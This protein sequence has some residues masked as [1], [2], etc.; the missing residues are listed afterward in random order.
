MLNLFPAS[1]YLFKVNNK[2]TR[3]QCKT[4]PKLTKKIPERN[5]STGTHSW[6]CSGVFLFN[7]EHTFSFFYCFLCYLWTSFMSAMNVSCNFCYPSFLLWS[8]FNRPA[9]VQLKRINPLCWAYHII[10]VESHRDPNN[11]SK[12]KILAKAVLD[13]WLGS[14]YVFAIEKLVVSR[15]QYYFLQYQFELIWLKDY[16]AIRTMFSAMFSKKKKKS[17]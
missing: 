1:I 3:K 17:C 7:F 9:D 12:I 16:S 4:C 10:W 5:Q 11:T 8:I 14:E 15:F 2:N 13:V 6:R